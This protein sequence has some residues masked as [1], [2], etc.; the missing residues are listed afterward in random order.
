MAEFG[1]FSAGLVLAPTVVTQP[2]R[3]CQKVERGKNIALSLPFLQLPM[4]FLA[5]LFTLYSITDTADRV[6]FFLLKIS[7]SGFDTISCKLPSPGVDLEP[8][9][10]RLNWKWI[11][12]VILEH[13]IDL[14]FN[15]NTN[16]HHAFCECNFD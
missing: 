4:L 5:V 11:T 3:K 6:G 9:S 12:D 13:L 7:C 14:N 10:S 1:L 15:T 8:V 2:C 16:D